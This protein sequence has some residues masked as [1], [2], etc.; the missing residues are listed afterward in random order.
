MAIVDS[1]AAHPC[2][3]PWVDPIS[4][5]TSYLLD[6]RVAPIQKGLYYATPSVSEDGRW[7]WFDALFPPSK[8]PYP[9][10]V[11][12]DAS[13]PVLRYFPYAMSGNP[14]V[15]PAGD[16]V[17][18]GI[19]DGIY[20]L[21]VSGDLR[22]VGRLP[23]DWAGAR[24]LYGLV[25]DM[26]RSADGRHFVL[27]SHIGN[28][29]VVSTMALAD[30]A[31]QVVQR[32]SRC[33]HHTVFSPRDPSLIMI[34]QGPDFDP[35]TGVK[36]SVIDQRIWLLRTSGQC[37]PLHED[38]RFGANCMWCHEWWTARGDIQWCDYWTGIWESTVNPRARTLIWAH[39][40]LIHG[41]CDPC[42]TYLCGDEN[43]YRYNAAHPCRLWFYDRAK[44]R[45]LPIVSGVWPSPFPER[46]HRAY[47]IDP[48]AHFSPD[49]ELIV[50]TTA[51]R[52]IVDVALTPTAP[53]I[54]GLETRGRAP[55]E[56]KADLPGDTWTGR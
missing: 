1:L 42:G 4:G 19:D 34:G 15:T 50:H 11:S 48:H 37:E 33:F 29:W 22:V 45:E 16:A 44:H 10:V 39:P 31:A 14:L 18:L 40:G 2:F 53:L 36:T 9:A 23:P 47:H 17:W 43:C 52:G 54:D 46:D 20:R 35:A 32:F 5:V 56:W 30:G 6:R 7:L 13:N 24:R 25:T 41:Q 3:T 21:D 12:L 27:D 38:L 51:A 8:R 28:E 49:G 55:G 26:S